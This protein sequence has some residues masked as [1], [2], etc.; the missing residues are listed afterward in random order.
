M[1]VRAAP[2]AIRE[3]L[4]ARLLADDMGGSLASLQVFLKLFGHPAPGEAVLVSGKGMGQVVYKLYRGNHVSRVLDRQSGLRAA[5]TKVLTDAP[6]Y[7][8]R[9]QLDQT[10]HYIHDS[11]SI[12]GIHWWVG[13]A[14]EY[15]GPSG[16][17]GNALRVGRIKHFVVLKYTMNAGNS[18]H[19]TAVFVHMGRFA[20][21]CLTNVGP[22]TCTHYRVRLTRCTKKDTFVHVSALTALLGQVPDNRGRSGV[23]LRTHKRKPCP[24]GYMYLV[25]VA[26]AFEAK[27]F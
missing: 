26:R 11:V 3:A 6:G 18:V 24:T 20:Q 25:P 27:S 5:A 9:F 22:R 13:N 2:P 10:V 21:A 1:L 23:A 19:N 7:P 12:N 4:I 8:G 15:L 17:G 16:W 14:C